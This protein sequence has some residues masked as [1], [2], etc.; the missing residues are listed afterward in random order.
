MIMNTNFLTPYPVY[1]CITTATV[2]AQII[3]PNIVFFHAVGTK[4]L[5]KWNSCIA[6]GTCSCYYIAICL[7]CYYQQYRTGRKELINLVGYSY[8]CFRPVGSI[9]YCGI[10]FGIT[11]GIFYKLRLSLSG[12]HLDVYSC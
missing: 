3:R 9:V 8:S 1:L 11:D 6:K 7:G 2:A 4:A 5:P 12:N 10:S